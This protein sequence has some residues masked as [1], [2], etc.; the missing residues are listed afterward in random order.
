MMVAEFNQVLAKGKREP[1][2]NSGG[3]EKALCWRMGA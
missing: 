2:R 1:L 3:V